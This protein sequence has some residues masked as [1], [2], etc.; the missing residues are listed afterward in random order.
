MP[1]CA[2]AALPTVFIV[3]GDVSVTASIGLLVRSVGWQ[4]ESF[5]GSHEFL[6]CPRRWVPGCLIVDHSTAGVDGLALQMRV[7]VERPELPVLFVTDCTDVRMA[8]QAM[9]SGALEVLTKPPSN[10]SLIEA[11]AN[12]LQLS[13]AALADQQQVDAL[14][15]RYGRLSRREQEVMA[16]V[17]GGLLNK[18]VGSQLGISEITVK[19]HRGKMMRKMEAK[20]LPEVVNMA[21]RLGVGLGSGAAV[22]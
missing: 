16:R 7:L 13:G 22:S 6:A 18:Q 14:R 9:K 8:V 17:V 11:I 15:R 4:P 12:A 3:S 5:P 20:S 1:P 19:A 2:A 10:E 21:A